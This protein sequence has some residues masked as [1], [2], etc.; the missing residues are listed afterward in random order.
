MREANSYCNGPCEGRRGVVEVAGCSTP[1]V[2]ALARATSN[3]RGAF[4]SHPNGKGGP[5][6]GATRWPQKAV[7]RSGM[8]SEGRTDRTM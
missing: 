4:R 6:R 3:S 2:P 8:Y 1:G 7:G 5:W